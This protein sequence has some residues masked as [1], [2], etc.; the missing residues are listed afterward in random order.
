MDRSWRFVGRWVCDGRGMGGDRLPV[1]LYA[2]LNGE[3]KP[4]W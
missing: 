3:V 4:S 2:E 1:T